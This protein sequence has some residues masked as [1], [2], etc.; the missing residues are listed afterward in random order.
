MGGPGHEVSGELRKLLETRALTVVF[1]PIYAFREARVLGF[2]ALVRGPEGSALQSPAALFSAAHD[3]GLANE[4]NVL[5]ITEVLRAFAAREYPGSLFLN[6]SPQFILKR[7]FERGR[8]ERFL[9]DLG[10][11]PD[12]VVIE[13]TEDHPTFDFPVVH[14]SLMLYRSMG[15]RIAIDDLGE[16]Y[17]GLT[18]FALLEP[19]TVKLDMSLIRGID[20][21]PMK[22]KLV[23]AMA[24]LCRELDARLVAEGVETPAERDT[25]T[26]LGVDLLQGFLFAVPDFPFPIPKI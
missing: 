24:T 2:E 17:S 8:A 25:L 14:D 1:Q 11:A 13:L 15:F 9:A 18:S 5:C 19:E 4:I 16:G 10:I 12:R 23:R 3:Q 22:K 7:G 26:E 21:V 20:Q 6:V